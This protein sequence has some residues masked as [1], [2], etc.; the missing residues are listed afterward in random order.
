[1][2]EYRT[3]NFHVLRQHE[4]NNDVHVGYITSKYINLLC[5][6]MQSMTSRSISE[7][8]SLV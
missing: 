5:R 6:S 3:F 2:E 1:M 8:E 7:T 4:R